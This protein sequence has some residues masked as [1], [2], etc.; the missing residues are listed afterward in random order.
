[1]F[2]ANDLQQNLSA[3][4]PDSHAAFDAFSGLVFADGAL[5]AKFKQLIA[6]AVVRLTRYSITGHTRSQSARRPC[7]MPRELMETI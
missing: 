1:L 2:L 3:P 4:A 5:P 7:S 6:V